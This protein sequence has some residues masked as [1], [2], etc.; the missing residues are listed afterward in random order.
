MRSTSVV[1]VGACPVAAAFLSFSP[2]V[3][4]VSDSGAI[5]EI[6]IQG[7]QRIEDGVLR[8]LV[9]SPPG[10]SVHPAKTEAL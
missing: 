9:P 7:N 4:Q 2:V 6:V 3:A 1:P 5:R 8:H 10:G